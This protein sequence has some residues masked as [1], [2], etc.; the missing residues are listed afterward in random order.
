MTQDGDSGEEQF[1]TTDAESILDVCSS[2]FHPTRAL[3]WHYRSQH[4]SL[5]A[6][7]NHNFYQGNLVI[8]PSPYGQGGRLGV[9]ATYLADA[10]Y[11][12][13][14]NIREAKR[15][16]DAVAEH[17]ATRPD[18]SLGVVTL[19][20]KQRDLIAELLDERLKTAPG[21]DSYR[22]HWIT[23]GQPLFIK[24]LENVQGDER[25]AIIISTT[26]GK[27][28]GANAVRQNFGPISRQGGWRRLNVL[29][30]RAK[31][32]I[33][34]YTSLRPED[35]IVDGAT[36]EGTK[37]LRNY[38]EYARTGLLP[39]IQE[40]GRDPDSDFEIAVMDVLKRRGYEVTP[41]LGVA[42]YRIDIAVK[43]PDAPGA[44]LAAIE[45]DGASYHSALSVR[46][47]DRIRQEILE[48]L[49]WRG[50]I[51]RIWSTDWFRTP[52]QETEKL[53]SFLDDLRRNWRPEHTSSDAWIEEG[54]APN[55]TVDDSQFRP[56][57]GDVPTLSEA[58]R[59]TVSAALI[60]TGE[61]LEVE[62]DDLVRYLDKARPDDVLSVQITKGKDD[63]T[64]GIVNESRP[65]AQALLGAVIGDEVTLHLVGQPPKKL[66]VIEIRRLKSDI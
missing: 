38:L 4:H 31:K 33:A 2:H 17:I 1:S 30:T 15:V 51:W 48:A 23:A 47:R 53:L 24:N 54:Q 29:F 63:F 25:D 45:C 13:Q 39:T 26:F 36:P 42:G 11:E 32:S 21:A 57:V 43:H 14:T 40:T 9:R 35:I 65:L 55:A 19:N 41:Q 5:I 37:A 44:Y 28:Q 52:R 7:S 62:V 61:D 3:R 49:G 60:D 46:D 34:L 6:F 50:R 58:D 10:V 20:I 8:F 18:E 56:T 27:P 59:K 16:V 66:L 12:Q 64:N 22:D